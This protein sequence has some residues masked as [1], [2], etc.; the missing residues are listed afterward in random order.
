MNSWNVKEKEQGK[1]KDEA[2]RIENFNSN[3]ENNSKIDNKI[4]T[5]EWI[6]AE[7]IRLHIILRCWKNHLRFVSLVRRERTKESEEEEG[8]G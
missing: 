7:I 3:N 5:N 6:H 8:E 1:V 2:E 4:I